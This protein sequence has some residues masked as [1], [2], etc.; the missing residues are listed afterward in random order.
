MVEVMEKK[1]KICFATPQLT[2]G[3]AE[4]VVS[5]LAS[6]LAD[7]GH[8]VAIIIYDRLN[9]EYATSENV[10][11][12]YLCDE[13]YSNNAVIRRFQRIRY[14]RKFLKQN[15]YEY[16]VAFLMRAVVQTFLSSRGLGI[17]FISTLRNNPYE[18]S[19]KERF[20]TDMVARFADAHFVQ[21]EMQ[22][23]Y[24]GESVQKKTFILTNPVSDVFLNDSK[25]YSGKVARIISVGRLDA[26]KNYD[27]LIRAMEQVL[28]RYPKVRADI[29]G[30]GSLEDSLK[31]AISEKG[32]EQSIVLRGR[33]NN[34]KKELNEADLF[35]MTSDYEGMPNSLLE[36][37]T[38]G[39]P[40][41]STDCPTGPAE[42][43]NNG[44]NGYLVQM[45]DEKELAKRIIELIENPELAAKLG[46][47]AKKTV[48]ESHSAVEISKKFLDI[49]MRLT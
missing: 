16:V 48:G 37:M 42:L 25:E 36:A 19:K 24:Y 13:Q 12:Y 20:M 9:N 34:I 43:I 31:G 47:N 41:I 1:I 29:W 23:D 10:K 49:C 38:F 28:E 33:S 44:E 46:Q 26:Q 6:T 45:N 11:K 27:M 7:M 15:K 35:V 22:K 18:L 3:G 32:L 39:M 4:R 17:K 2:G 40:C 30:Q 5:I 14:V 21:N 8:D